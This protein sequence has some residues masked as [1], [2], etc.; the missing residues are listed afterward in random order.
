MMRLTRRAVPPA[1]LLR[2]EASLGADVPF[3]LFGGCAIGVSRGDEIYPLPEGRKRAVLIVA[4]TKIAV[5]TRAAFRWL[6]LRLT[7][8]RMA[9]KLWAFCAHCWDSPEADLANDF[10]AAVFERHPEL[11]RIKRRLLRRGASGAALAG[12]GSAVFGIFPNPAQARRAALG[13]PEDQVF[14]VETLSREEYRR[15]LQWRGFPWLERAQRS[16]NLL[17]G[18]R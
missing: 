1:R 18:I 11:A 16:S 13:F 2:L 7:H 14:V 6:R 5:S 4:P 9:P 17:R 8:R 3:F 15:A 10:E 12:S